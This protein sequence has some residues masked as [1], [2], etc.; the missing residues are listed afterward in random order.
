MNFQEHDRRVD[1]YLL[2]ELGKESALREAQ[3][4]DYGDVNR[5]MEFVLRRLIELNWTLSRFFRNVRDLINPA[6][7]EV[8][9]KEAQRRLSFHGALSLPSEGP[10]LLL[11]MTDAFRTGKGTGIQRVVREIARNAAETGQGL[12]VVIEDGRLVS[13]YRRPSFTDE[14]QIAAGDVFVMLDATW[15]SLAE[16]LPIMREVSERGGMNV[17]CVYDLLPLMYPQAFPPTL[18]PLFEAWFD[19]AVVKSDAV[20]AISRSAAQDLLAYL[21]ANPRQLKPN[22]RIGWWRLGC[23]F[24]TAASDAVSEKAKSLVD[25]APFF[26]SVGT[27]EP[28]KCYPVALDAFERLWRSNIDARY[29]IVGRRGWSVRALAKRILEHPEYGKRLFWFDDA[30]DADLNFLYEHARA[31]VAPSFAE[32]FGLPL[33]EAARHGLPSIASDIPV[34]REVGGDSIAYFDCLDS[35]SLADKIREAL[36][37]A[38]TAPALPQTSWRESTESFLTLIREEK[39]QIR[40]S[41]IAVQSA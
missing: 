12:P 5:L 16:Y 11:D 7:S 35:E 13:Y 15:N 4:G 22:F 29:V 32:G 8:A 9:K 30:S 40:E 20:V 26:L 1:K 17:V 31:A 24:A 37:S 39:Y 25:G 27:L 21:A 18:L 36:A 28:R 34:F 6:S 19:K 3:L 2:R 10:R 33:I 38:K 14:I 23:D 41:G